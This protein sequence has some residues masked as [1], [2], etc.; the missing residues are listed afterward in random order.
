MEMSSQLHAT[1][2]LPLQ[3]TA[4]P[5]PIELEDGYDPKLVWTVVEERK[6]LAPTVIQTPDH[7]A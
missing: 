3:R 1:A 7:P 6:S 5:L 2:A 4:I